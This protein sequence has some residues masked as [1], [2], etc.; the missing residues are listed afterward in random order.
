MAAARVVMGEWGERLLTILKD[1]GMEALLAALYVD[2][3]RLVVPAIEKGKRWD[4]KLKKL[5]CKQEWLD[6]DLELDDSDTRRTSNVVK[7]IMNSVF[8]DINF[9]MEIA[10]DFVNKRLPTLDFEM[11]MKDGKLEF[12]F[13]EKAMKTPYC[14]MEQSAMAIKSKITT[15]SQDLIRRMLNTGDSISQSERNEV[16]EQFVK[17]LKISGYGDKQVKD[18]IESGLKG[19]ESK[20]E[21]AEKEGRPLYRAARSSLASRQKKKL[22][23]KTNWY[24]EKKKL[25]QK[26]GRS[27]PA[28]IGENQGQTRKKKEQGDQLGGEQ[29]ESKVQPKTISVLFVPR[30]DNGELAARLRRAEEEVSVITGDRIKIVE[31]AGKKLKSILHTPNPWSGGLCDR[32][33]C[34][35]CEQGGEEDSRCKQRNIVYRTSCLECKRRGLERNYYG[36]SARTAFERGAEHVKDYLDEKDDSHMM[37]HHVTEHPNLKDPTDFSMKVLKA[38]KTAFARQVHEAVLIKMNECNNILNSR[39]EF[40]RC[41]LPRLSVM[42]GEKEVIKGKDE[43][44]QE[45]EEEIMKKDKRKVETDPQEG[46]CQPPCKKKKV[47]RKELPKRSKRKKKNT[48]DEDARAVKRYKKDT[49]ETIPIVHEI[50]SITLHPPVHT[51]SPP[52]HL[53]NFLPT[54][55]KEVH[56]NAKSKVKPVNKVAKVTTRMEDE[57]E[58]L[59]TDDL[60]DDQNE[61]LQ[62]H[63]QPA[64]RKQEEISKEEY[65]S[66][67]RWFASGKKMKKSLEAKQSVSNEMKERSPRKVTNLIKFFNNLKSN[68][69]ILKNDENIHIERKVFPIFEFSAVSQVGE[70][71]S[72]SPAKP[73]KKGG[74]ISNNVKA[75]SKPKLCTAAKPNPSPYTPNLKRRKKTFSEL[76][77]PKFNYTK[78]S[79]I[80]PARTDQSSGPCNFKIRV[81]ENLNPPKPENGRRS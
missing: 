2:D 58:N 33:G 53:Y 62:D 79:Q 26:A 39:G 51:S 63:P 13:F 10:E 1:E 12:S 18:I 14:I 77:P 57:Q 64:R 31:R 15:L 8:R 23:G 52:V 61:N 46:A 19:Y 17:R 66:S 24:K 3:A 72:Q 76:P 74:K 71:K 4:G 30:T 37:K 11:W 25:D 35:V 29:K 50:S 78:L 70:M 9:E 34:L 20:K 60:P 54:G 5:V 42:M 6:E 32:N 67:A 49:P 55:W 16:V 36:E 43:M 45:E 81:K 56:Q 59:H 21:R 75:T 69:T 28:N 41:Q 73:T 68:S 44:S 27:K 7:E 38:H 22:L 65:S 48:E 40:N 47:W 80:F